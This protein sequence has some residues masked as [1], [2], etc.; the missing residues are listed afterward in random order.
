MSLEVVA[1]GV[2]LPAEEQLLIAAG[3]TLGQ[4]F[5]F[6]RPMPEVDTRQRIVD[7]AMAARR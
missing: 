2:E 7:E 6:A 5:L 4:G 3:C 1:E